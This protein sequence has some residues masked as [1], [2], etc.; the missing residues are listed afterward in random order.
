MIAHIPRKFIEKLVSYTNI[1]NI[2]NKK[3]P[4]K[5]Q[6][7]NF[8]ACCPFHSDNNPSFTVNPKKQFYYCFSCK[9]Y[10]NVI[11]F[12]MNYD[13]L[14]FIESVQEL[15]DI[16]GIKKEA[17]LNYSNHKNFYKNNLHKFMYDICKFY[18]N[19]LINKK[20]S[21]AYE[22]L[23][24]RGLTD[25]S[26]SKFN[27]GFSPPYWNNI[28]QKLDLK[29]YNQQIINQSGMFIEYKNKKYDRF[30]NRVMFPIQDSLGRIVAFGGRII[31]NSKKFPKYLNSP[32]TK[33]F[34]KSQCLYGFYEILKKYR[35]IPYI[36]L[37]E[38][39]IDVIILNQFGIEYTVASLGTA[40]AIHHIKL[41][42]S[43]T[44]KIVC[45]YD[46]DQAGKTAA[47][48]TLNLS[49]QYLTDDREMHFM[50][51]N[52]TEDPDTLI[53]KV[54]KD[55]FLQEISKA[56]NLS[57]FL[58]ETLCKKV[59][60]QTL[61]GR[62]KLSKLVLPMLNKI[63]GQISKLFLRQELGNKIG[64]LD[65]NKLKQ[66]LKKEYQNLNTN[67]KQQKFIPHDIENILIRLL[68]QNPK[69]SKW[70]S[71][72]S[73]LQKIKNNKI[74]TFVQLA[75]ICKL[76][77]NINTDQLLEHYEKNTGNYTSFSLKHLRNWNHMI[78][79]NMVEITFIDA[80]IKLYNKI[81]E[82]RQ[83]MLI[84]LDRMSNLTKKERQELWL[85]NKT[86]S[87][88]F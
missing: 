38:G 46:G 88:N 25:D 21:Y 66:L 71:S 16:H 19:N 74:L 45:C 30:R 1:V 8:V 23:K 41:L 69:L 47:W 2:I 85:L 13:R 3:F 26:I 43:I 9:S 10:G 55:N 80:L 44:N 31:H 56:K 63:P 57:Y 12:L 60:L 67:K 51:L 87:K 70:I 29:L 42:Y 28:S 33:Y 37:V 7:E 58:F 61:E 84:S 54:G 81:L 83:N 59:N 76:Y 53:R 86:L 68:I 17:Y 72:I 14:T 39:Y 49:L 40:I 5:K 73:E 18:Q 24:N 34:K 27:I 36:L 78:A 15:S 6:G 48:R 79:D 11:N 77:P 52:Q 35:K 4:L 20:Y 32:D 50:F 65:D 75:K 62:I 22:Y 64:I 82:Q